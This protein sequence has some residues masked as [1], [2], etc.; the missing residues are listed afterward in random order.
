MLLGFDHLR[1]TCLIWHSTDVTVSVWRIKDAF[2][3]GINEAGRKAWMLHQIHTWCIRKEEDRGGNRIGEFI[4]T[5]V[6]LKVSVCKANR[7]PAESRVDFFLKRK[8]NHLSS[9]KVIHCLT[10]LSTLVWKL[11]SKL[12]KILAPTLEVQICPWL[13]YLNKN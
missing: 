2:T 1:I 8:L 12:H 11:I 7:H 13:N 5:S 3:R 6:L 4:S 10:L 9:D